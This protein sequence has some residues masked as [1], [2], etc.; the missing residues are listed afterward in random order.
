MD[1]KKN[2]LRF[3]LLILTV[4][5]LKMSVSAQHLETLRGVVLDHQTKAPL[6]GATI[7]IRGTSQ[8]FTTSS[9][10]NGWFEIENVP[11]G[12]HD[13]VIELKDYKNFESLKTHIRL[14]L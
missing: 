4:L 7:T 11:V 8:F 12:I 5:L 14:Q 6:P 13:I 2:L 10:F 3:T 9:D 1:G